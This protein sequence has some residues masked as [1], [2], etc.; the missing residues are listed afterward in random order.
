MC[1]RVLS[2]G[3]RREYYNN[4]LFH[5]CKILTTITRLTLSYL[6]SLPHRVSYYGDNMDIS[7][8]IE[9]FSSWTC[10]IRLARINSSL[11]AAL[12]NEL[13]QLLW[14]PQLIS[15]HSHPQTPLVTFTILQS[16]RRWA[17]TVGLMSLAR[18]QLQEHRNDE[19][20][21]LLPAVLMVV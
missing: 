16:S 5:L 10:F 20:F 14:A 1:Q 9:E 19:T 2:W 11:M 7:L 13:A 4:L 12:L 21:L 6:L 8:K 18:Q 17:N 3:S 15:V